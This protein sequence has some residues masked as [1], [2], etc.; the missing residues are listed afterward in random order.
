MRKG[1]TLIEL[2]IVVIV[3]G[4]LATIAVPQ[5][6]NAVE[7]ARISKAKNALGLI[8]KAQKM[9]RAEND[10]YLATAAIDGDSALSDYV[11]LESVSN[12]D[13]WSYATAI[14]NPA[15][16]GQGFTATATKAVGTAHAGTTIQIDQ[17]G[18]CTT[19]HPLAQVGECTAAAGG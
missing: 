16:G 14:A 6:L 5:F 18:A 4:I 2:L 3:I 19:S 1:F 9:Y 13:D 11:E 15:G 12:D 17:D 7:K 8:A 10:T